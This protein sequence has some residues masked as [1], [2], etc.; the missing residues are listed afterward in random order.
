MTNF[1]AHHLDIAQ[2]ALGRDDSGPSTIEGTAKFNQ[3][4]WYE[5][6][7]SS[8]ILFTYDDGVTIVCEQGMKGSARS[9]V[10][11]EGTEGT[12]YVTRGK[13]ESKPGDIIKQPLKAGDVHL[14]ESQNHHANWL[15]CIK[16]RKAPIADVAIGHRSATVCHL[17]N[18][19]VRTGRKIRW[20]PKAEQI[21]DDPGA[22]EMLKRPYRSPWRLTV[23]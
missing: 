8:R 15:D 1:G 21:L 6:P 20:D 3:D 4:G 18:I 14:Y 23:S 13:L 17:G 22:A 12:L 2:W 7:E 10:T 9:G 5:V 19:A 11:F 16:S